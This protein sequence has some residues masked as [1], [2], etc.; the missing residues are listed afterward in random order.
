M[1]PSDNQAL[2]DKLLRR[3][4]LGSLPEADSERLHELS[5]SDEEFADRLD[6]VEN[7]LVDAY[8]QRE[9]SEEDLQQFK[10]FYLSS[11]RRREKVQFAEGLLELERRVTTT[12]ASLKRETA[13]PAPQAERAPRDRSWVGVL[14]PRFGF[15]A[16]AA[17]CLALLLAGG[18]LLLQNRELRKQLTDAQSHQVSDQRAI[19]QELEGQLEQERSKKNEALQDLESARRSQLNLD[20]LTIVSMVL[21]APTRSPGPMPTISVHAGTDLVVLVLPLESDDFTAYRA[22]LKEA[23]A[24]RTVWRSAK[25]TASQ[26]ERKSLSVSFRATLLKHQNYILKLTGIGGRDREEVVGA[27]P[28]SVVVQ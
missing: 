14:V 19:V 28:F 18:Y 23:G 15:G 1:A 21:P 6:A 7:D 2:D 22:E 10:S 26:E 11:P 12:P 25:V 9:L 3:Y 27:Y 4:L 5:V 16:L 13:V 20:Q 17:A 8:V 24:G